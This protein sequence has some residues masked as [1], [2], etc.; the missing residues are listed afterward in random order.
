M[1]VHCS[2]LKGQL[3]CHTKT[4]KVT[5]AAPAALW[6]SHGSRMLSLH[7][8]VEAVRCAADRRQPSKRA[9]FWHRGEKMDELSSK[10][11]SISKSMRTG[12]PKTLNN[13]WYTATYCSTNATTLVRYS[14]MIRVANACKLRHVVWEIVGEAKKAAPK[15]APNIF[16][17]L[18]QY[19]TIDG[20]REKGFQA[21]TRP[22]NHAFFYDTLVAGTPTKLTPGPTPRQ[23]RALSC[24]L[25][26]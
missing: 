20:M 14:K 1:V 22:T 24:S 25:S 12:N 23:I 2:I 19:G 15:A 3:S 21:S 4:Y 17:A 6:L 7:P 10:C 9:F 8:S 26:K 13:F 5:K 11:S 18:Q 16:Q